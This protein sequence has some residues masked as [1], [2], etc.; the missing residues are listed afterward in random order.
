MLANFIRTVFKGKPP[1]EGKV[2]S[3]IAPRTEERSLSGVEI[4]L[5]PVGAPE[6]FSWRSWLRPVNRCNWRHPRWYCSGCRL[7]DVACW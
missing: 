3:V 7:Q 6:L 5:R 1:P 2:L 4:F